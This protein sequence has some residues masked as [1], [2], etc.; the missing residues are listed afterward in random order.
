MPPMWEA[1]VGLQL[2]ATNATYERGW[3]RLT[4]KDY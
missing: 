1:E 2:K 3:C 4:I